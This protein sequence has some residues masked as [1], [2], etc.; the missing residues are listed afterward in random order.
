MRLLVKV[1]LVVVASVAVESSVDLMQKMTVNFGRAFEVCKKELD[2]PDS[3][4]QE[5]FNFWK[6]DYQLTNR[7]A[8][9]ALLCMSKKLDL[10]DPEGNMHHGN[11]QEYAK[12]HGADDAVA[13]QLVDLIHGC[14]KTAAKIEDECER[15]LNIATCFKA[16][17]HKLKWAPD[18]EVVL[19]E[20]L[21]EV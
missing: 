4:N 20:I 1:I 17:I 8:G 5:F 12:K 14:E 3:L 10:V 11:A 9:C 6:E 13:K 18:M 2:L 19:A 7:Q 15:A 21:T 16:E